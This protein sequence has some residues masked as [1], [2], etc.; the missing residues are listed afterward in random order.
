VQTTLLGLGIAIILALVA[1]LVAPLVVDWNHYRAAFEAE[2]SRLTGLSVRV[3]GAIDARILPTP[4]IKLHDVAAGATG[5]EPQLR[6]GAIELE[7]R[8]GP[9]LRGDVQASEVRLVAP[10]I[11]LGLDSA[12]AVDWPAL[13]PGPAPASGATELSIS[14]LRIEDGSLT[15]ADAA[16]GSRFALQKLS[17]DGDIRSLTG[18]FQG[19]GAFTVGDEPY[20]YRISGVHADG[21][22]GFKIR[23]NADPSNHPLTTQFDGTLTVERG[24]PQFDGTLALARPVGVALSSGQRVMSDPWH[25]TGTVRATPASAAIENL[26]FQY[27]PD[28]RAINFTGKADLT[29]G[30][31]PHFDGALKA[32]EVDIDR[33]LAAPDLTRRP[34]LLVIKSFAE[35]FVKK[36]KLPLPGEINVGIDGLTV[37]GTTIR[38]LHGAVRFDATGWSLD[39]VDL[40]APGLTEV[41]LGGRLTQTAQGVAFT[42]PAVLQSADVD[43]LLAWLAGRSGRPT[44]E[45]ST[46]NAR[47]DVTL[48]GDR[49]AVD[50][51]TAALDQESVT[52]R[53]AYT[54]PM[55]DRPAIVDADLHAT[56]LDL[57]ALT[58]FAKGAVDE[59]GFELPRAGSLALDIGKATLAG[60]DARAVRAQV[61]FDA[62]ALQIDRL[63][64]AELGGA[65]LDVSGRID[66]LSSQP[67]GSLTINLDAGALGGLARIVGGFAPQAASVFRRAADRLA[68]AKIRGV[69]T[70]ERAATAGSTAKFDLNGQMGLMRV[71]LGGE[72]TGEPAHLGDATMRINGKLDADDGT[73]LTTLLGLDRVL[74]VD[75]LPG[76]VTLSAV[77]PLNGDVRVD[78]QLSASGLNAT[79]GGALHLGGDQA[80]TGTFQVSA[81]AGDLR[82]LAQAMTGQPGIAVPVSARAAVTMA[83]SDLSFTQVDVAV[84]KTSVRGRVAVDL[85]NPIVIDGDVAADSMDA[86]HAAAL[87][88]GLP[89]QTSGAAPWSSQPVGAGAFA[90][91]N[92]AIAFKVDHAAFTPALAASGL[93]GVMRFRPSEIVFENI[94]GALA[95]GK[96]TGELAFRRDAD[97]LVGHGHVTLADADAATVLQADKKNIDGRLTLKLDGDGIGQNP[98]A[99]VAALHGNGSIA[100][101]DA[102]L[103][104]LDPAAFAAATRAADPNAAPEP[105]KIQAAVN[106]ALANGRLTVPQGD[107]AMTLTS[108]KLGVANVTLRAQDGSE[109]ALAGALDL[110]SGALDA[111]MTLS[112]PPP[113]NALIRLR[114]E[115]AVTLK[116]PLA[117]P[118]RTL[119]LTALTG[120]LTLRAAELQT[121]RLES[122]EVNGRREVIGRAMRPQSPATPIPATSALI[123]SGMLLRAS[124]GQ[125]ANGRGLELL[126]PELPA[127]TGTVG[128][129]K[130]RPAPGPSVTPP[131]A[132]HTAGPDKH[133]PLNLLGPQ[134]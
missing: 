129:S 9:L 92:G 1:A 102:H 24:V 41:S 33:A 62:G 36:A 50:G 66:E 91:L 103:A 4:I 79:A 126:Q 65:A 10:Q 73:A 111:R 32:L 119:D 38:S 57:D 17:F 27:G 47:G 71:A 101:R 89:A 55:A 14:R 77:G 110:G 104:G 130:P 109:L 95:G 67:R 117:A 49:L 42:G 88:L 97:G 29:F 52:G 63:S 70:V 76:T 44:G 72:A 112:A 83:G 121:R 16:S 19:E 3:N 106:A 85:A 134:N 116:G 94:G 124:A 23:L 131:A 118:Q 133:M 45:A 98:A 2:A 5:R 128:P 69:L 35:A 22:S 30:A 108:G 7:V 123:E 115:L 61:K 114:P 107:A 46:L 99:L 80:P 37:G 125:A 100:F 132:P 34:P 78:G 113:V 11:R 20:A 6:A 21:G 59:N 75:Q 26:A 58:A 127:A 54:W 13:A 15:F 122:I 81:S 28:E 87:L 12:G 48:A 43:M 53:L 90:A 64:V 51:L 74:A 82:P 39:G 96:L 8:L 105:A 60:V 18:P 93:A 84:G 31:Q 120:W 25:V 56:K 86:A 40:R 68:P